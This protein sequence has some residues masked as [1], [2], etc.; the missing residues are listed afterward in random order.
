MKC[1]GKKI[2]DLKGLAVFKTCRRVS[3]IFFSRPWD[4]FLRNIHLHRLIFRMDHIFSG[5]IFCT[6]FKDR[7][8][9]QNRNT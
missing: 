6:N 1:S 2:R 4:N 5:R 9:F 7:I 8:G 3:E